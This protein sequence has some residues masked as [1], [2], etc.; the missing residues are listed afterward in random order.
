MKWDTD[1]VDK[2]K[3]YCLINSSNILKKPQSNLLV[4]QMAEEACSEVL[5]KLWKSYTKGKLGLERQ[6]DNFYFI[7]CKMSCHNVIIFANRKKRKVWKDTNNISLDKCLDD[8]DIELELEDKGDKLLNDKIEED[9]IADKKLKFLVDVMRKNKYLSE[10]D[11]EIFVWKFVEGKSYKEIE[12]DTGVTYSKL[13]RAA[14]RI[15]A[16]IEWEIKNSF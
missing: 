10:F 7:S 9:E 3:K 15:K 5:M 16:V 14:A 4:R 2:L 6:N 8:T 13:S 12:K 11:L 1:L